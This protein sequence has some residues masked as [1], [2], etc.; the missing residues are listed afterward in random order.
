MWRPWTWLYIVPDEATQ[1][2]DK[3]DVSG[4]ATNGDTRMPGI[5]EEVVPVKERPVPFAEDI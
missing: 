5:F 4:Y 3:W 2:P 1:L